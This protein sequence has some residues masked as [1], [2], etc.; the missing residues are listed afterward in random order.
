MA[1]VALLISL[2]RRRPLLGLQDKWDGHSFL[3][4]NKA[5]YKGERLG[6][7]APGKLLRAEGEAL[8]TY[9][10]GR[11]PGPSASGEEA[12]TLEADVGSLGSQLA[13][14]RQDS[15]AEGMCCCWR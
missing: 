12:P 9:S 5:T 6:L 1:A 14:G 11:G 15:T 10:G 8:V 4:T 2:G 3:E 7:G 13:P